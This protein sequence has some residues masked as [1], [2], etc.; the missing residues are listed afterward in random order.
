MEEGN[1]DL[2]DAAFPLAVVLRVSSSIQSLDTMQPIH[3]TC[4]EAMNLS[5]SFFV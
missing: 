2:Y 5:G 1:K 3:A 4:G